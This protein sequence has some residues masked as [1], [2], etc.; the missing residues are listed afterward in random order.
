LL[1]AVAR[2][3][4]QARQLVRITGSTQRKDDRQLVSGWLNVH[5]WLAGLHPVILLTRSATKMNIIINFI[6][7][8]EKSNAGSGPINMS[9]ERADEG[10]SDGTARG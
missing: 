9:T 8:G 2:K 7:N 4:D 10:D 6:S 5:G 1:I 3:W